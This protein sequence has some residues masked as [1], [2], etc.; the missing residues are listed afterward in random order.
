LIN[1]RKSY[2]PVNRRFRQISFAYGSAHHFT[3]RLTVVLILI[4]AV[5]GLTAAN[6]ATAAEQETPTD[7]LIVEG[8]I[9]RGHIVKF[10]A[11]IVRFETVY[12]KGAIEVPFDDIDNI[13]SM[14]EFRIVRES[15]E[16]VRGFI[17]GITR[18]YLLVGPN[19]DTAEPIGLDQIRIGV[20]ETD[21]D[22]SFFTRLRY[23]YPLW[24]GRFALGFNAERGAV[25]KD[26]IEISAFANRRKVPTRFLLSVRYAYE[27]QSSVDTPESTTKDEFRAFILGEYDIRPGSN[28][29]VFAFPAVEWD[30]PRGIDFRAYPAAGIG[31]RLVEKRNALLQAQAGLGYIYEEFADFDDNDYVSGFVGFEIAYEF[32]YEITLD[33]RLYYYPSLEDWGDDWLFRAELDLT[34]PIYGA[35]AMIVG[36]TNTNDDNPSPEV[37]NNK[38]TTRFGL[39]LTF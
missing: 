20:P 5:F 4:L 37:G 36:V 9:L 14:R 23:R 15:G 32:A 2:R 22:R 16:E 26:K 10:D 25:D 39:A 7:E 27:T 33:G 29:F 35:L 18:R 17:F 8:Q 3:G 19:A 28:V 30:K 34:V 11:G 13:I 12:G 6:I 24:R 21:F 1:I 38:F 31:Y